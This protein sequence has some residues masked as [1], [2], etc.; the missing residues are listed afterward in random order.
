MT[1]LSQSKVHKRF[2]NVEVIRGVDLQIRSG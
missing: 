1:T 2:G